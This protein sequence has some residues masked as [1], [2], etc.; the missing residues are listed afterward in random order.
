MQKP[1]TWSDI[2]VFNLGHNALNKCF[3]LL[4][5][6]NFRQINAKLGFSQIKVRVKWGR[7]SQAHSQF[8]FALGQ[9]RNKAESPGNEV[10]KI[11]AEPLKR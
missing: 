7:K 5:L 6:F 9:A 8:S 11:V 2:F 1:I 4:Y 10:E 3:S